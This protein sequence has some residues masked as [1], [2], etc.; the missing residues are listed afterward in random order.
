MA[1]GAF[2]ASAAVIDFTASSNTSGTVNGIGWS[3]V[4]SAGDTI[5][6]ADGDAP[7]PIGVLAG[8]NDGVGLNDD[9]ISA[10]GEYLTIIFDSPVR[11][12]G[13][14]TLDM[15]R[16]GATDDDPK[17]HSFSQVPLRAGRPWHRCLQPRF[18]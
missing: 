10:G 17:R 6:F 14:W 12:T 1:A 18:T 2:S 7:G 3:L 9:E 13:F 16:D 4:P 11:V 15:F 5:T 8:L